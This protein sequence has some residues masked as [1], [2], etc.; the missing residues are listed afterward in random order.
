MINQKPKT[1][2]NKLNKTFLMKTK[3]IK[4]L[5]MKINLL[6][7]L[8]KNQKRKKLNQ[9]QKKNKNKSLFRNLKLLKIVRKRLT[10]RKRQWLSLMIHQYHRKLFLSYLKIKLL[11]VTRLKLKSLRQS[12]LLMLLI[13]KKKHLPWTQKKIKREWNYLDRRKLEKNY[14]VKHKQK[15][16]EK[17]KRLRK[18]D[19][20]KKRESE[21]CQN[22]QQ[23]KR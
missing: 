13:Q 11:Y 8:R 18:K 4:N 16:R 2:K 15:Q 9:K 5:K 21:I 12:A 7:M 3:K 19:Q 20:Q 10:L 17:K 22:H 23:L 6:K 14:T 1:P